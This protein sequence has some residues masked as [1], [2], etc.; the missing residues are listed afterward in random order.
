MIRGLYTS[1]WSMMANARKMDVITNNLAN[2]NTNGFKKDGVVFESFPEA[3][4]QRIKDT[5][6]NNSAI[7]SMSLG[8]DV[9]EIHT[10]NNPGQA[11]KTDRNLDFSIN[12]NGNSYFAI[13][14]TQPNGDI[15]EYYTRDGAFSLDALGRLVNKDGNIV[16]GQN[17]AITLKGDNFSV[18]SDGKI[19]Q[20]N[21]QVGAI[22]IVTFTNPETLRKFG[23]N[24]VNTTGQTVQAPFTGQVMQGYIEQSN[25]NVVKEMVDMIS[26]TR[27]YEA[28]QKALQAQDGTLEKAVNEVGTLR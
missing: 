8:S 12:D 17:G 20:N 19:I 9:G 6:G 14:V 11:V 21:N 22:K 15:Q 24:M 7:G 28:S 26:V 2:A 27:A 25:V 3:L 10:Y 4:T 18:L 13:G 5:N 16:M 23:N 1:G